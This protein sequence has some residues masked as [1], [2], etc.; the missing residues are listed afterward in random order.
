MIAINKKIIFIVIILIFGSGFFIYQ[1]FIK[2]QE[3]VF[4]LEKVLRGQI[5]QEVSET[6]TVKREQEINLGFKNIGRI[7][8]IYIKVGDKVGFGQGLAKLDTAQLEIQVQEAQAALKVAEANFNKLLKGSTPEEIKVAE[9][10]VSN[11]DIV[12]QNADQSLRN[13]RAQA[14]NDLD[15]AYEDAMPDLDLAY[16]KIYNAFYTAKTTQRIY[17]TTL[18]Q[19]GLRVRESKDKI[20]NGL[21]NVRFLIETAQKGS[22]EDIDI[23]LAETKDILDDTAEALKVIKDACETPLYR[24]V[25]SSTDKTSLDT[26]RTDINTASATIINNKQTISFT[27]ISNESKINDAESQVFVADGNLKAAQDDLSLTK[28]PPRQEDIN[29]Y[30]AQVSQSKAEVNLLKEQIQEATLKSPTQGQITKVN[31]RVGETIQAGETTIS[32]LPASEFQI[33]TDIYEEDIVKIEV[34]NETDITLAAF[35]DKIF[36]GKVISIDPAEKLIDGIVYYEITIDFEEV[37][38]EAKPGMTADIV[39]KTAF[40]EDVLIIPEEAL[41]KKNGKVMVQVFKEDVVEDREIE[42]GLLGSDG[43]IEVISGLEEGEEVIIQ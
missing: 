37:A 3:P 6:G 12:L 18:S 13:V 9:T 23:A 14:L 19:E 24:D 40:R 41:Q 25:I 20:E 15:E 34:G 42:I 22:N 10:A 29:L 17:F 31:K 35:P 21:N 32:L 39:I 36:K 27:R 26:K 28:A 16:L 30:E 33:K 43:R 7:E 5:V 2:K 1:G 11:A 8:R 4:T 38:K